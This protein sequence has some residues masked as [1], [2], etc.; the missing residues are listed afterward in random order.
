MNLFGSFDVLLV[1][2]GNGPLLFTTEL[3]LRVQSDEVFDLQSASF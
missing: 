3:L 2:L 1:V